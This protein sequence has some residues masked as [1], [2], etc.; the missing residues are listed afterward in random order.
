LFKSRIVIVIVC[1]VSFA[2]AQTNGI[3]SL[4]TKLS[5][6]R[7]DTS[8]V[9]LL[10]KIATAYRKNYQYDHATSYSKNSLELAQKIK[11]YK[12]VAINYGHLGIINSNQGNYNE[13]LVFH[14]KSLEIKA[15]LKDKPGMA[16]SYN[17]IGDVNYLKGNYGEALTN[18]FKS[19]KLKEELKDNS[20][21][22]D[23]YNNI[24]SVYNAMENYEE[25]LKYHF[26]SL[27]LRD[28][29][30]EKTGIAMSYNNIA[31]NYNAL[32]KYAE[33]IDNYL[34]ALKRYEELGN[35]KGCALAYGNIGTAYY[36]K[37][38]YSMALEHFEK[39]LKLRQEVNDKKGIANCYHNIANVQIK[40]ANYK[41]AKENLEKD[42]QFNIEMNSLDNIKSSYYTYYTLY[43]A[44]GDYKSALESYQKYIQYRDSVFNSE[45]DKKS[46][47]AKLQY[48]FDKQQAIN[49]VELEK[50]GILLLNNKQQMELLS[51]ENQ[52][53]ELNI[54]RQQNELVQKSILG[55]SQKKSIELLNKDKALSAVEAQQ[56][57]LIVKQQKKTIYLFAA[58]GLAL[59]G[60]LAIAY[61]GYRDKKK[62][63]VIILLQKAEVDKQRELADSRREVAETQKHIIE[64]KQKEILDSIHYAKRIQQAMLTSRDYISKHFK[65]EHFIL[66]Q[67]KDIVS[68]DF[69][70]ALSHHDKFYIATADCT[71]HGVPGAFMSLLNISFLNGNVIE[72]GI[73]ET[74]KILNE[75]RN[76]II[77][78]LNPTGNEN[79]KDG[80]DCTLCAFDLKHNLLQFSAANNPLWL[81]RRVSPTGASANWQTGDVELIEFK[82]DKMPVG[83]Y[84]ENP[85]DFTQQTIELRKGDVIYTFTDGYADQFGGPK[86]KKFMYRQL[87]K[88]LL[89]I[90]HLPMA[91]QQEL[92]AQKINQWKGENEQVDDILVIGVRI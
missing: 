91:Q 33:A 12:Y 50:Q 18:H 56:K 5:V 55:E 51:A 7:E 58:G 66:Y 13:A 27:K 70:W 81:V 45:N 3:D 19:L 80:M 57:E 15:Q 60:L 36:Y 29:V 2:R 14:S 31:I 86:N 35:K 17:N 84:E 62:S 44:E 82:A 26:M 10:Y 89:E 40:L 1:C 76:E 20:S 9:K 73:S 63:N 69:Y 72:R 47:K 74:A 64:D 46:Y 41:S 42:L 54:A 79:S 87:E 28:E 16:A 37:Q 21:I 77:K 48:D 49:E 59:L 52:L 6:S 11:F 68:G 90:H 22:A 83:K 34:L 78:A 61:K 39:S 65:A 30:K 67:P 32:K 24:G 23:S 8:K 75:Q 25:S 71:G 43:T 4:L 53:K 38:D 88:I 92:L 85:K